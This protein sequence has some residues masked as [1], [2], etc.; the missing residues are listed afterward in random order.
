M[1]SLNVYNMLTLSKTTSP[2]KLFP[3]DCITLYSK[4]LSFHIQ[5]PFNFMFKGSEVLMNEASRNQ[6]TNNIRFVR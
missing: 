4:T 3:S 5:T 6:G 1:L 2:Q